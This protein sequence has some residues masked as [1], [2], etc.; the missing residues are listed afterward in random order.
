MQG[1]TVLNFRIGKVLNIKIGYILMK[2]HE[3]AAYCGLMCEGCPI[4]WATLEEDPGVR[5]RM[6]EAIVRLTRDLYGMEIKPGDVTDC[7]GCRTEGERL[8]SGCRAC[9]I[10]SCARQKKVG[11]CAFCGEYAC[12]KLK[13]FFETDKD[14]RTRLEFIRSIS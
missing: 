7:D 10:R 5:I 8:F 13:K 1:Y 6:R 3:R 2:T 12:E 9:A 14:A 4:R 11:S